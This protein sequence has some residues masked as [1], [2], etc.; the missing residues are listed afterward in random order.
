M[1]KAPRRQETVEVDPDLQLPGSEVIAEAE[2]D[3]EAVAGD[4]PDPEAVAGEDPAAVVVVPAA[5]YESDPT[6]PAEGD[7][8]AK[9]VGGGGGDYPEPQLPSVAEDNAEGAPVHD[10]GASEKLFGE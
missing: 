6:A 1:A 8:P 4:E 9:V 2:G 10:P 3:T 7:V 5:E